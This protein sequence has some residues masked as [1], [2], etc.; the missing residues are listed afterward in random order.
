MSSLAVAMALECPQLRF[1]IK[2][3]WVASSTVSALLF[4]AGEQSDVPVALA[5]VLSGKYLAALRCPS[6]R[7]LL[8]HTADADGALA[9]GHAEVLS[10]YFIS[11]EQ[12]ARAATVEQASL[13]APA[14]HL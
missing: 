2:S 1:T 11:V 7:R 9:V 5:S 12:A 6:A 8:Q 14:Q 13:Q 10:A 4:H 3:C